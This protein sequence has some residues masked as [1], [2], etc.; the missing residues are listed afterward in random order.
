MCLTKEQEEILKKQWNKDLYRP[1]DWS[2]GKAFVYY[3]AEWAFKEGI[4][5]G[6]NETT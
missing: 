4:K 1:H 3:I 2:N 5:V 6:K